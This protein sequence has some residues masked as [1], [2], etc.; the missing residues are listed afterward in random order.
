MEPDPVDEV[1]R[2]LAR[3]R[4]L[5]GEDAPTLGALFTDSSGVRVMPLEA[6]AAEVWDEG[7]AQPGCLHVPTLR[8]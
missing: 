2:L 6:W 8:W 7:Q 3:E 5:R 4:E 1:R